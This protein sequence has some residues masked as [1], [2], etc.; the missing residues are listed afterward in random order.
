MTRKVVV[1]IDGAVLDGFNEGHDVRGLASPGIICTTQAKRFTSYRTGKEGSGSA[2][3]IVAM[4]ACLVVLLLS[5][6][7]WLPEKHARLVGVVQE[8]A[9][10]EVVEEPN[11]L[12]FAWRNG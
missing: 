4:A 12:D 2:S 8:H 11:G 5:L 9:V 1:F 6:W 10:G 7:L 3:F